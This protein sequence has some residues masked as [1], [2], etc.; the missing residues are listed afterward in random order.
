MRFRAL[1]KCMGN[2][3]HEFVLWLVAVMFFWQRCCPVIWAHVHCGCSMTT[4]DSLDKWRWWQLQTWTVSWS[5]RSRWMLRQK[6][7]NK[8]YITYSSLCALVT[9]N[10]GS[11]QYT[12][13]KWRPWR[14]HKVK[15][16][17]QK[18]S[19]TEEWQKFTA[20]FD[21]RRKVP[22]AERTGNYM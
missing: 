11:A 21:M 3:G 4:S 1:T 12:G 20:E 10:S 17:K 13:G 14:R 7:H 16:A 15:K 9:M 5:D 8:L 2:F 6:Q 18:G 22:N 19:N